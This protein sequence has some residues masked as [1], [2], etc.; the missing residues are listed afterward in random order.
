MRDD[1]IDR[2]L[3]EEDD[4]VPSSGFVRNVMEGVRME[5][6]APPAIPFPWKRVL[7]GLLLSIFFLVAMCVTSFSRSAPVRLQEASGPS[8]LV[9]LTTDFGGMLSAANVGGLYW[10]VLA[11]ILTF[12]SVKLSLRLTGRKG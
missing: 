11:L 5:A 3:S 9:R 8:V 6:S 1:E 2:L 10:I 7:P 4:L 12:V